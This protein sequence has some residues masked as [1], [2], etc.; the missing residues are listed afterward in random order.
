MS[1]SNF[2]TDPRATLVADT[3]VVINLNATGRAA[4]IL[5]ALGNPVAV[6]DSVIREL[7]EGG[8]NGHG[9]AV[10]L[11]ALIES[12]H[13]R[14]VALG[15]VGYEI[16]ERLIDGSTENTLD[17]GEAATIACAIELSGVAVID[18]R[19]ALRLCAHMFPTLALV[20]TI[21]ILLSERV[22]AALGHLAQ[23]DALFA[24]LQ[25]ARMRIPLP[26]LSQTVVLIGEERAKACPSLP[27]HAFRKAGAV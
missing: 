9:D 20:P 7:E 21:G 13:V 26:Y 2:P 23:A 18:E 12:G 3:S 14:S 17:D 15:S 4:H 27:R 22:S 10:A 5:L 11:N 25:I 6:A 16:Y 24:A 19:K 8:R 1:W